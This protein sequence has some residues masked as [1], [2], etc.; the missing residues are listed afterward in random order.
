[1]YPFSY[2]ICARTRLCFS[3]GLY[4]WN[5]LHLKLNYIFT[6]RITI[7]MKICNES[8]VVIRMSA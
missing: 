4:S 7:F 8:E 1:M 3:S 6:L 2:W 5:L